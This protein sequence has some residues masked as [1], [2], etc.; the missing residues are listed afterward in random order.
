[1]GLWSGLYA[2]LMRKFLPLPGMQPLL[3]S[4]WPFTLLT[5]LFGEAE[6]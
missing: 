4:P 1:V 2:V 3:S 6:V 5:E